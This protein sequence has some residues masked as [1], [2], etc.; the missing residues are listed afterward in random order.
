MRYLS[1]D[2]FLDDQD[3][4]GNVKKQ[5]KEAVDKAKRYGSA[6]AI[7]H[8]RKDT[9]KALQESKELLGQVKLVGIDQI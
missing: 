4:V 1:R 5:I 3:G 9:I 8:P 6:I 7:G 2:V